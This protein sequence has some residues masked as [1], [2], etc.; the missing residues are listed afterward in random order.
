MYLFFPRKK[1]Y[2]RGISTCCWAT[3]NKITT[4]NNTSQDTIKKWNLSLK[5]FFLC[6]CF[7]IS[8]VSRQYVSLAYTWITVVLAYFYLVYS[9]LSKNHLTT[10]GLTSN[11]NIPDSMDVSETHETLLG[12]VTF[13]SKRNSVSSWQCFIYHN[14]QTAC[15]IFNKNRH[16][17]NKDELDW[18]Q[19]MNNFTIDKSGALQVRTRPE[20]LHASRGYASNIHQERT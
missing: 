10:F 11:T 6:T 8:F 20:L 18:W 14:Y 16:L 13:I 19:V 1:T 17:S 12:I 2:R 9:Y 4:L 7:C 5:L 15:F 3:I